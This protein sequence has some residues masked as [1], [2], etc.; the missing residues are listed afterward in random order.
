[1]RRWR[2]DFKRGTVEE[3]DD[4]VPPRG[5]LDDPSDDIEL[6]DGPLSFVS[7]SRLD[8][9]T[10]ELEETRQLNRR[11]RAALQRIATGDETPWCRDYAMCDHAAC[12][13]SHGHLETARKAL[14]VETSF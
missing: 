6:P 4:A 3:I 1:M 5:W 10:A 2:L 8:A 11:Y 12:A 13:A 14:D 7:K 9:I